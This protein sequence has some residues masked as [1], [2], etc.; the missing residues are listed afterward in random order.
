MKQVS[1]ARRT[2]IIN[3]IKESRKQRDLGKGS[4]WDNLKEI[5]GQNEA[6]VAMINLMWADRGFMGN[7]PSA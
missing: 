1:K 7:N 2:K 5:L 6:E 3:A 4:V